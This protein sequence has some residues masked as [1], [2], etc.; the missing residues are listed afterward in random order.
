[1]GHCIFYI[2]A[3]LVVVLKIIDEIFSHKLHEF[4]NIR[5]LD[6]PITQK[7]NC[8]VVIGSYRVWF[9]DK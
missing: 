9:V 2:V 3:R 7:I 6:V 1:M 5:L 4:I 8:I